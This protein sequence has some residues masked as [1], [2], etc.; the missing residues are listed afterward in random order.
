[1]KWSVPRTAYIRGLYPGII[2]DELKDLRVVEMSMIS[3][4]NP[5]TRLKLNSKGMQYKY[6]HGHAHSYT[7]VNDLTAVAARLPWLPSINTYAIL[8]YKNDVCVKELRYR[9]GVVRK[10]LTWL[11]KYNHLYGDVHIAYPEDWDSLD[12]DAE[13]EPESMI[14]DTIEE[15]EINRAKDSV[16]VGDI[17]DNDVGKSNGTNDGAMNEAGMI[18]CNG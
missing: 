14:I 17:E 16:E 18:C 10:A 5:V 1:M 12:A 3:I 8:K 9:P 11:K 4:Y 7:I 13:I 2:P 6:F 15:E